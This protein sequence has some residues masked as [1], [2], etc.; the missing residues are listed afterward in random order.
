MEAS[1][2]LF[3]DLLPNDWVGLPRFSRVSPH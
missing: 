3:V 2:K 1:E